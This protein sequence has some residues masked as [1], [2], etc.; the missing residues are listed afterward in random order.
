MIILKIQ[1]L[2]IINICET[3]NICNGYSTI[4][5][6]EYDEL[7]IQK[8]TLFENTNYLKEYKLDIN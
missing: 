5:K 7:D 1:I 2:N 4:L 6:K 3:Y 8:G